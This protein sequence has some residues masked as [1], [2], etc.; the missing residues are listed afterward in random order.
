MLLG[1]SLGCFVYAGWMATG[2]YGGHAHTIAIDP[3][4]PRWLIVGTKNALL[5]RSENAGQSWEALPFPNHATA[6]VNTIAFDPEDSKVIYVGAADEAPIASENGGGLY[7]STDAGLHWEP[8]P[9]MKGRS[10]FSMAVGHHKKRLLVAG[11][12]EGV[13]SSDDGG[14]RWS[15]ISPDDNRELQAIM[16]LALDPID[17][18][19]IYAGTPHL[20]WKTTNG[21][22]SW[23]SIHQGMIDDSDVFSIRVDTT[24]PA[25]VFASACSGIY[26]ST[27][28]GASWTKMQGIPRSNRRTHVI[29]QD[30]Q[31][32]STVYAGTSLGLWKSTDGGVRWQKMC[33]YAVRAIAFDPTDSRTLYLATDRSGLFKS[34][35]G[36]LSYRSINQGFSNRHITQFTVAPANGLPGMQPALYASTIYDGDF[37]GV[38]ASADNGKSWALLAGQSRLLNQNLITLTVSAGDANLL[39]GAGYDGLLRST[40][41][42]RSWTHAV[43]EVHTEPQPK[44]VP[45]RAKGRAQALKGKVS[46]TPA[47]TAQAQIPPR[48]RI[49]SLKAFLNGKPWLLAGTSDGLYGSADSGASWQPIKI[50]PDQT[51]Q[52]FRIFVPAHGVHKMAIMTS[53]GLFSSDDQGQSWSAWQKPES[54][55]AILDVAL[56]SGNS[57]IILAA[58]SQGLIKSTDGGKTWALRGGGLPVAETTAVVLHPSR[59]QEAYAVQLGKVYRSDDAGDSWHLLDSRGLENVLIRQLGLSAQNPDQLFAVSDARG[60]FIHNLSPND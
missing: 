51:L 34:I 54:Q 9:G 22:L 59:T 15:K 48:A 6:T 50:L 4:H 5:F 25:R 7:R 45:R 58:T 41:G 28:G 57:Q 30:P 29:T 20:P 60:I 11:T 37:G 3:T 42:G 19:T 44:A 33:D 38:F 16:A 18:N 52:V 21:G 8:L 24:E 26:R 46:V 31:Q 56:S 35:D 49:Y 17:P 1:M 55:G 40:D 12:R 53:T 10:I 23:H 36:G 2:P 27:N 39:F 14:L 47:K 43:D 32:P 13:Y